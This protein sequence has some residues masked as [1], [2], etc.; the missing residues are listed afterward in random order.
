V[1][2]LH[3]YGNLAHSIGRTICLDTEKCVNIYLLV[4]E[5][6]RSKN[7]PI[8]VDEL[9]ITTADGKQ[10]AHESTTCDLSEVRVMRLVRGG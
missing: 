10:V 8:S 6:L 1:F 4:E 2:C 5:L 9:L 3:F 7:E